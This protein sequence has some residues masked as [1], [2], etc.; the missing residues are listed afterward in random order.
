[1]L[2]WK[3]KGCPRCG[4]DI[5]IDR[6]YH[7]W[8]EACLQC[9]YTSELRNITELKQPAEREKEPV[10]VLAGARNK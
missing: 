1:M 5:S 7:G 2:K 4:G 9:G 10:R 6:D 8:Y 3:L